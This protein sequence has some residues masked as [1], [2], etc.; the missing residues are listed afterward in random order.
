MLSY[1]P[2]LMDGLTIGNAA[3][4]AGVHIETLRYHE[5][6]Q[7]LARPPRTTANYRLYPR[8]TVRRVRFIKHAQEL[9]FS[10]KEIKELLSIR[11]DPERD[12]SDVQKL[13]SAKVADIEEKL[14]T[15]K[16]MKRV[17]GKLGSACP[18]RGPSRDYAILESLQPDK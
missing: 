14:R 8:D 7:L 4:Q 10:L 16:R 5:R 13:A 11:F 3:A 6:R 9:G 17:L 12:C 18:G 2:I 1:Y 15:L